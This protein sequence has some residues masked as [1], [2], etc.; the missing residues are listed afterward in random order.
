ME[1]VYFQPYEQVRE[2][3]AAAYEQHRA[4]LS[5][6][7]PFAETVHIGGTSLPGVRTKGDL[8]IQVRVTSHRFAEAEA[9]LAANYERN[10]GSDLNENYASFKNDD[11]PVPLGIQLCVI[12]SSY[13]N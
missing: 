1:R 6:L 10:L 9:L 8:D 12:G 11:L 2:S 5:L 3:A 7:L 4:A 13:D